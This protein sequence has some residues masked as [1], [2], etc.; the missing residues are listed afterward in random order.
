LRR[1]RAWVTGSAGADDLDAIGAKV[2]LEAASTS[3]STISRTPGTLPA[4]AT[5]A[6]FSHGDSTV[7]DIVAVPERTETW[8]SLERR[9]ER[10]QISSSVVAS[11]SSSVLCSRA[12]MTTA[13]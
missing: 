8:I 13:M 4:T 5:R 10:R 3:P 1:L 11:S 7:P 12:S 9:F 2:V 6:F